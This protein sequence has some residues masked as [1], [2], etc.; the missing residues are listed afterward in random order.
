VHTQPW[1]QFAKLAGL[2][3]NLGSEQGPTY[4]PVEPTS[5][6]RR[7]PHPAPPFLLLAVS[8]LS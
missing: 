4:G 7:S 6:R 2:G 8:S 1:A 3:Q 5:L